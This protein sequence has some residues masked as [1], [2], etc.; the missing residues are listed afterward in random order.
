MNFDPNTRV[1]IVAETGP[2]ITGT[3]V[4]N[5]DATIWV[6]LDRDGEIVRGNGGDFYELDGPR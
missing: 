6:R 1:A 2:Q 4:E 5:D 3:V